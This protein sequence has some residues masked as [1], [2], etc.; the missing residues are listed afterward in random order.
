MLN[1]AVR[2]EYL[3]YNLLSNV[4]NFKKVYFEMQPDKL[5]YYTREQFL[6]HIAVARENC[7]TLTDW[8]YYDSFPSHTIPE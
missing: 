7:A 1:Y 5:Q 8:G 4:G 2:M 3:P 6:K